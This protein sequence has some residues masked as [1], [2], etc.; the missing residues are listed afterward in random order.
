MHGDK[1]LIGLTAKMKRD[2]FFFFW[3]ERKNQKYFLVFCCD[4]QKPSAS[5]KKNVKFLAL[6]FLLAFLEV[7]FLV[8]KNN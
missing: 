1:L 4:F 3:R 5:T 8:F 2:F 6:Y 7:F